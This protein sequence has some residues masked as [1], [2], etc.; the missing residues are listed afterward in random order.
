MVAG[1]GTK[2]E[3]AKR[4]VYIIGPGLMEDLTRKQTFNM[5]QSS[6]DGGASKKK[7]ASYEQDQKEVQTP[8]AGATQVVTAQSDNKTGGTTGT[9]QQ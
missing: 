8:T 7:A 4:G 5:G 1:Q 6:A 9:S 3:P 2:A